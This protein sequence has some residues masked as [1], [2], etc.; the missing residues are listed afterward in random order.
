[1]DILYQGSCI[2]QSLT[3]IYNYNKYPKLS[4]YNSRKKALWAWHDMFSLN[5][6]FTYP[7]EWSN[8]DRMYYLI[9]P[10]QPDA[11]LLAPF[12]YLYIPT[13]CSI[14]DLTVELTE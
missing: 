6:I 10:F 8:E 9:A 7:S 13:N 1:M 5:P 12:L 11:N 3:I 14:G 4:D 2:D